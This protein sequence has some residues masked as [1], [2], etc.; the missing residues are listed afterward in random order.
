MAFV[1]L[2]TIMYPVGAIY[3]SATA[4]SPTQLFGGTWNQLKDEFLL[5]S[6]VSGETG[7]EEAHALTV[8]ELAVHSHGFVN[9]V[10]NP[11]ASTTAQFG[12]YP[13]QIYNDHKGN[14]PLQTAV[15][16]Y[17]VAHNNMPPYRTCFAW[18]RKG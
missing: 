17:G 4:V 1:N 5:P 11:G 15:S 12:A 10:Y 7:G 6:T 9:E 18:E 3:W 14:W 16:G 8:S 2:G 13:V